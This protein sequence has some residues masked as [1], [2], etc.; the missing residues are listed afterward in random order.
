MMIYWIVMNFKQLVAFWKIS[1]GCF[2]TSVGLFSL[3]LHGENRR[4]QFLP[5]L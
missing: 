3:Y 2:R 5:E 4:M 1:T